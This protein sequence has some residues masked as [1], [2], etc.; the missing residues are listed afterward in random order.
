MWRPNE[1][2]VASYYYQCWTVLVTKWGLQHIDLERPKKG[3]AETDD[4]PEMRQ[5]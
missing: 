2:A 1:D 3:S 5:G 4:E